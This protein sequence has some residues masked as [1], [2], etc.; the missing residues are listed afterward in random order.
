MLFAR[1][2][3]FF[4]FAAGVQVSYEVFWRLGMGGRVMTMSAAS[5][6]GGRWG[7]SLPLSLPLSLLQCTL[8]HYHSDAVVGDAAVQ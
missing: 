2:Q 3:L 6:C 4:P 8:Q 1:S 5:W 7:V